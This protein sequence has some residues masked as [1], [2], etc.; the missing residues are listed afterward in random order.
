MA[1]EVD[2][3]YKYISLFFC[4][5]TRIS[6]AI[7]IMPIFG[8]KMLP[9]RIRLMLVF[10]LTIVNLPYCTTYPQ[11]E[12]FSLN[13]VLILIHQFIIGA[14]IGIVIQL[15]FQVFSCLG[16]IIAMQSSLNFA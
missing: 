13:S 7:M 10:A 3:I 14:T 12:L 6:A 5:S 8:T 16:E 2:A 9:G 4:C 11:I 1:I 15:V